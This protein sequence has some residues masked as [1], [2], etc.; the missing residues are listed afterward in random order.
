MPTSRPPN[1]AVLINTS[2]GW[3][4]RLIRG[5]IQY[6]QQR[7]PWSLWIEPSTFQPEVHLPDGWRGNGIIARVA[8]RRMA[9]HIRSTGLPCVNISAIDIPGATFPRVMPDFRKLARIAA[10]HLLNRGF[11]H[12]GYHGP[13]HRS[14]VRAH[15][16]GFADA[17]RDARRVCIPYRPR[18]RQRGLSPWLAR[19]TD[20]IRWVLELPKPIAVLT[21]FVECGR[22]IID[23][24][25][26][27]DILVP[28][29]VAVLASDDDPLLCNACLPPLSGITSSSERSGYQAAALLD[30][31]LHGKRPPKHPILIEPTSLVS[32]RS[33]DTLAIDDA[34]LAQ[35]ISYLRTHAAEPL[36]VS[37]VLR[38]VPFSRRQLEQEFRRVLGRSPAQEIRRVRLERAPQLLTETDLPI[39]DVAASS[40]FN[41]PE[42]FARTFKSQFGQSPLKFR[43]VT[44]TRMWR[45]D[46][47]E[48]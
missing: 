9:G 41:S 47:W 14:L 31:L 37:D 25:R 16:E 28:E 11:R 32:R 38:L 12:F 23:A 20:L 43:G 3:G 15:Y 35:A 22:D 7:G 13:R 36:Y 48:P 24:C 17:L 42:H 39:P 21:W 1:I 8:T 33:T 2:T 19:H 40:G 46:S 29:E 4:Q 44:R 30:G 18:R 26:D 27:A 34:D 6:A 45:E 10:E 5:I